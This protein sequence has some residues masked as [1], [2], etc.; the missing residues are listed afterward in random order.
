M[1]R[2]QETPTRTKL[3]ISINVLLTALVVYT[4]K[5]RSFSSHFD[6][7]YDMISGLLAL[8]WAI[9]TA[10]IFEVLMFL[11]YCFGADFR[12]VYTIWTCSMDAWDKLNREQIV[13]KAVDEAANNAVKE[14][15]RSQMPGASTG[16]RA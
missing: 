13:R 10:A 16:A 8:H 14:L 7:Q 9:K 2:L 11:Y 1:E 4:F 5:P 12:Y 3:F 15:S 6:L